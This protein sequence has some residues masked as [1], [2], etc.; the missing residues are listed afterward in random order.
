MSPKHLHELLEEEQEPFVLKSYIDE[1]RF[2]LKRKTPTSKNPSFPPNP[3][4]TTRK[5]T[6]FDKGTA[7]FLFV[8]ALK[9]RN[10][11]QG[12]IGLFGSIIKRFSRRNRRREG[13]PGWV[14]KEGWRREG[15]GDGGTISDARPERSSGVET[16][17]LEFES[18]PES[19][20]RRKI[21]G[22]LS[23]GR[24]VLYQDEEE[25]KQQ[26]S[27][28]S[29]LDPPFKEEE[30]EEEDHHH[31][32]QQSFA[33]VLRAKQQLLHRISRFERLAELDPIELEK[34]MADE[35]DEEE[36]VSDECVE[37]QSD[38]FVREVLNRSGTCCLYR[39]PNDMK[40]LVTDIIDEERSYDATMNE[41]TLPSKVLKRLE[42]W[43]EVVMNTID[44]MVEMDL[45]REGDE[46][47]RFG[48]NV[49]ETVEEIERATFE[50][51]ID[52]LCSEF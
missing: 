13:L 6:P 17:L 12:R 11:K 38:E 47:R 48:S 4:R 51:L 1:R 23:P 21:E 28:V 20:G 24:G 33:A 8:A 43:K 5:E 15:F 37:A 45:K 35:I 34:R 27:P 16:L 39:I 19:P 30:E 42:S 49:G 52:E 18:P 2:Q 44:M 41:E 32:Q 25:E 46:W 26:F 14:F 50:V 7:S 9:S 22:Q 36:S 40:M 3:P 10:V 29:V 31:P